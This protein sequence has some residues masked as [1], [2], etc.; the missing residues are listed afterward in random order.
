MSWRRP[1]TVAL[2]GVLSAAVLTS[3]ASSPANP[4]RSAAPSGGSSQPVVGPPARPIGDLLAAVPPAVLDDVGAGSASAFP[5]AADGRALSRDGKPLVLYV[6]A[7][8][9]PFCAAQRWPLSIALARFGQFGNLGEIRS[10]SDDSYPDTASISFHG[11]RYASSL[12]TFSGVELQSNE[13]VNGRRAPLDTLTGEDQ[14]TFKTF[15]A[16]P[17]VQ[18]NEAATVP[19]IALGGRYLI[20]HHMYDP[21]VLAGKT[22]D[23]IAAAVSDPSTPIARAVDGAANV[24]TA[25]LCALTGGQPGAVCTQTGVQAASKSLPPASS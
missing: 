10:A 1:R 23:Q 25:A 3:C 16:P 9:C 13:Q 6:G 22:A 17:W 12:L 4:A 18:P 21:S 7:E 11:A 20:T 8:W 15:D 5:T 24:I 2:A 14:Q 19:F